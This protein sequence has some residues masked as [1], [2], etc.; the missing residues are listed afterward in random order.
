MVGLVQK[1]QNQPDSLEQL[2]KLF[3]PSNLVNVLDV[4]DSAG[5]SFSFIK[6]IFLMVCPFKENGGGR[7]GD[8][9]L[10]WNLVI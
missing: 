2:W 10:T 1:S 8:W 3:V 7:E 9:T 6:K 5:V 4:K